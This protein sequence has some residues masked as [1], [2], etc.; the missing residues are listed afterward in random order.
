MFS[1]KKR[2]LYL[3]FVVLLC[4][5]AL[6]RVSLAQSSGKLNSKQIS[7]LDTSLDGSQKY[8]LRVDGKPFYM[9]NIQ[10]RLDK[11]RYHWG[12]DAIAR[13]AIVAQAA[14][15]GFNTVSIPIQWYEVEPGKNKF[16]WTILDEYLALAN[17]YNLKVELLWF[18]QN[19]GGHVQWLGD[20][21]NPVH[22]RTPDYVLYSPAP[23]SKATTSEFTIRRDMSDY[24]LDLNDTRLK[25]RETFV[26][27]SVMNHVARWDAS[28]GSKHPV[29]GVQIGNEVIGQG[30]SFPN[31]L[32][33]S[34]LSYVGGAVKKSDYG[35]WTRINCVYW[36]ID[37]RIIENESQRTSAKGSNIDFVGLDTYKTHRFFTTPEIFIESMRTNIPYFGK[38]Y[39]MFMEV[40][41]EAVDVAQLQMAALSGNCA[42]DYYDMCG[43]DNHGLY[44]RQNDTGF[45]PHGK[46]IDD[47]RIVNKLLNSAMSDIAL[48]ANGYGLFVHNWKGYS[49]YETNSTQGIGFTPDYPT[50]QGIS[51]SRNKTEIV[52]MSTK[53][54]MFTF[55]DS[56]NISGANKGYF[57]NDNI[58]VDQGEVSLNKNSVFVNGGEIV[59]LLHPD[60]GEGIPKKIIQAEFTHIGG[61]SEVESGDGNIGFAGNGYVKLPA[62]GAGYISWTKVDGYSGGNRIIRIRYA[63]P[64]KKSVKLSLFVN[65]IGQTIFL[66]YT[67]SAET[68]KYFTITVPLN[69]GTTNN[70]GLQTNNFDSRV[71]IDE[72]QIL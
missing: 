18:S 38:N 13:E 68:Y 6:Q 63:V 60:K 20:E 49:P 54:G 39:R 64:E 26:L 14:S 2:E 32:I 24:S 3:A 16:N 61:G 11:L 1:R 59:R 40:G 56:L 19:S 72:L 65:G 12:W 22:L 70:I 9:T 66:Q 28:N 69:P 45:V 52:L 5:T 35:V 44:D 29:I 57:N 8:V 36:E 58:W 67:G 33:I 23:K 25:E 50:S 30:V 46:Y 17:K 41:A 27:G 10:I 62:A 43:P 34:Y 31:P 51:I 47:V 37:G 71:N 53:G 21:S 7:Y 48:N 42:F 4:L 15:D 55:P